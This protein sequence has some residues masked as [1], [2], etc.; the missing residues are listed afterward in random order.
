MG[1][2]TTKVE[3]ELVS[4]GLSGGSYDERGTDFLVRNQTKDVCER[5]KNVAIRI[6]KERWIGLR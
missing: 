5:T 6:G 2:A 3:G 1:C 4:G